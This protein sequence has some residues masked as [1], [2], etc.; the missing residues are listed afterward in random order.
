MRDEGYAAKH[1]L[2][3]RRGLALMVTYFMVTGA[4][5]DQCGFGTRVTSKNWA[6]CK[7]CG[8]RVPRNPFPKKKAKK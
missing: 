4:M 8:T 2:A 5:C 7:R 6:K 1:P 3:T